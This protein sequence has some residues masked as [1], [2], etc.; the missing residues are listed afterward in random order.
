MRSDGDRAS[1]AACKPKR[2]CESVGPIRIKN[3]FWRAA[4]RRKAG[5]RKNFFIAKNIDS[6]SVQPGFRHAAR[7]ATTSVAREALNAS[8]TK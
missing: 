3:R 2:S 7:G 4:M 6:E 1:R 5:R 8:I